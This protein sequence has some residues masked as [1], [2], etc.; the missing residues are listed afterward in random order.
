MRVLGK[1]FEK[2]K[3]NSKILTPLVYQPAKH[4]KVESSEVEYFEGTSQFP[5]QIT[6][7]GPKTVRVYSRLEFDDWM[8]EQEA[9]RIRVQ[10]G[11]KVVGTYYFST[12]RSSE[13]VVVENPTK[14]PGKWRTCE[15]EI[16]TGENTFTIEIVESD[17]KVLMRFLE[18]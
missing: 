18:F 12:E 8:G 2:P 5:L 4:V 7:A 16:P 13:A 11:K 10:S 1:E 15:F 3:G 6:S 17:R 9:Y 14:V